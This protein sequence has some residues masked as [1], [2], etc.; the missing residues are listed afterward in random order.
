MSIRLL[1]LVV[2]SLR[3]TDNI[4]EVLEELTLRLVSATAKLGGSSLGERQKGNWK[5]Q[6]SWKEDRSRDFGCVSSSD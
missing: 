1:L 4:R 3:E 2:T 5:T 6:R